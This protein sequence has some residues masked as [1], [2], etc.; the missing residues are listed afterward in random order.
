[1]WCT[2]L[3]VLVGGGACPNPH[4]C[5]SRAIWH[6]RAVQRAPTYRERHA[7]W[8]AAFARLEQADALLF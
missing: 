4:A 1:M 5:I 7:N 3:L 6:L 8:T 2:L